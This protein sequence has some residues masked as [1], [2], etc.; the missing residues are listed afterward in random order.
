LSK[1]SYNYQKKEIN[2]D[3]LTNQFDNLKLNPNSEIKEQVYS[4]YKK[5][6]TTIQKQPTA[7]NQGK[8]CPWA[9]EDTN[10]TP[11]SSSSSYGAYYH[12][13]NK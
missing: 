2:F 9:V 4:N 12:A 5:P 11:A 7:K 8:N 10:S 13:K 1:H 6:V 3:D